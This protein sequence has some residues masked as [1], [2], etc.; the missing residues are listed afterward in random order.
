MGNAQTVL[1]I[2]QAQMGCGRSPIKPKPST[3]LG[4]ILVQTPIDPQQNARPN[5]N[6]E[7]INRYATY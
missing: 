6:K 7:L 5:P 2:A 4:P 3:K 1:A